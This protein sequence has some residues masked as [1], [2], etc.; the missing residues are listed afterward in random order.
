MSLTVKDVNL[1]SRVVI[2]ESEEVK[3]PWYFV[4]GTTGQS[5]GTTSLEKEQKAQRKEE[6]TVYSYNHV[7]TNS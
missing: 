7:A 5:C 4:R 3:I 6:P 1:S 2:V